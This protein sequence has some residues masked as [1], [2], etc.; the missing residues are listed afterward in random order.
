[1]TPAPTTITV[2]SV[3]PAITKET[4][5]TFSEGTTVTETATSFTTIF[6]PELLKRQVTSGAAITVIPT[7]VPTY[8]SACSGSV[9]YS[10][11]CSC[12][13]VT[14]TTTTVPTPT[15]YVTAT[16]DAP[17]SIVT[18]SATV[19][20]TTATATTVETVPTTIGPGAR[21]VCGSTILGNGPCACVY[22]V[23]CGQRWVGGRIITTL[24]PLTELGCL[25]QCDSFDNCFNSDY[26]RSTGQCR[27]FARA[28]GSEAAD[29]DDAFTFAGSCDY[30]GNPLCVV[31]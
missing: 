27:V 4:T 9:R 24:G 14:G 31:G 17:T 12:F 2:T 6:D 15:V 21:P 29:R 3:P 1:M 11:A 30:N 22:S 25:K 18:Y 10:S 7:L 26:D 20:V 28:E 8:A 5:L 16:A 13:G 19:I 23:T